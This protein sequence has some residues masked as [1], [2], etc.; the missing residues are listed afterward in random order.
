MQKP[1]SSFD[2]TG[3]RPRVIP[4]RRVPEKLSPEPEVLIRKTQVLHSDAERIIREAQKHNRRARIVMLCAWGGLILIWGFLVLG[5][6]GGA[7]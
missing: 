7:R 3:P 4:S 1:P 6:L 2:F 5:I